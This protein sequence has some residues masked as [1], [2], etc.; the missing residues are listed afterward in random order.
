[1][2]HHVQE[3]RKQR[4]LS[5]ENLQLDQIQ[6]PSIWQA[7]KIS[8]YDTDTHIDTP[9][10]GPQGPPPEA[11]SS[12]RTADYAYPVRNCGHDPVKADANNASND[13]SCESGFLM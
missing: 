1:M 6:D 11:D 8:G 10:S 7:K 2:R 13:H 5:H 9:L 4:K 12:V 3:K